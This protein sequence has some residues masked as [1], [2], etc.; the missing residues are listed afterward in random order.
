MDMEIRIH[1]VLA[2]KNDRSENYVNACPLYALGAISPFLS[3][4]ALI[5]L[6][7]QQRH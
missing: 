3:I 2:D 6:N 5:C 1:N 7:A 4:D